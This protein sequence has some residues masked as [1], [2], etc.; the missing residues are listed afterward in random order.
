M[1]DDVR[2]YD[3]ALTPEE[4]ALV[5]R[6][7]P[8]R[9][10]EPS[11]ASGAIADIRTAA[12][13]TWT[14]GDNASKHEVYFGTEE[15]AVTNADTSDATG[16]YRGR[17]GTTSFT[18]AEDLQWGQKYFWRV[19]ESNADGTVTP[20]RVWSFTVAGYLIVDDFESY[21]D[22]EGSR[23]Y[24]TWIDGYTNGL[25]GST[26]GNTTAPFAERTI[27]YSGKQA[28]PLDYNNRNTPWYSEAEKEFSPVENWTF[29]EANTLVV[30]FR[31]RRWTS[32]SRRVRSLSAPPARTSGIRRM[33]SAMPSS[34]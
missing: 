7:D 8:L 25:S 6:I 11:P 22:L 12:P 30:H 34:V 15:A 32:W 4:L 24:E 21:T 3:K 13:L 9:A 1:I 33:S 29:G 26:V 14:K 17:L 5:M 20:G 10:C 16:V 28:M 19:D 31:A 27:I 2:L 23:I 18:P